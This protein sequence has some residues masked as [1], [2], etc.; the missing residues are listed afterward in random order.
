[1]LLAALQ[2]GGGDA[3]QAL[4]LEADHGVVADR[5]LVLDHGE[6]DNATRVVE[7]HGDH[8]PYP[9]TVEIDAAAIAQARGRAFKDHPERAALLGGMQALEPEHEAE[10]SR[11]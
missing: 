8:F 11:D 2:R 7:L 9:D 3:G 4:E 10:R 1:F 6:R 5:S